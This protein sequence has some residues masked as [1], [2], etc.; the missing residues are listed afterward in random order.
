[1]RNHVRPA[2]PALP[3]RRARSRRPLR[4][5]VAASIATAVVGG[6][7][8]L[9]AHAAPDDPATVHV[10]DPDATAE[11]RSLFAYLDDVRGDGI[12]FGHQHTTS[13]GLTT[14]PSD[15]TTSDVK[16]D[17]GDFPAV[18]GWDTLILQ[19]DEAPGSRSATTAQNVAALADY[20]EKADALGGINTLSAHMENFVTGGSFYDTTGDTLR[21]VLPG[22][23]KNADL[24]AYLDTIA[25][26]AG[27]VHDADGNLI[28][29]IFRPWH[30]N[31]GSWFWWGAAFG[32]PG[33]YQE[34]FRYTVEY[35][36][37]VRG[38]HNLL[39]AFSP[40]GGFGG[41]H[42]QY[43][44]TYPGDAFVDVLGLD[45][46][47]DT[48]SQA[49]L[50]GLVADL[51]M[52]ADEADDRGKVSAFTE[53]G[54]SGGVGT[55]GASPE[56]WFTKVLD[57]I[58]GDPQ[59]SRNSYMLTWANFDAGQ[60]F[61]PVPGDA[62]L[63]D[64]QEFAAD[65]YVVL[66]SEVTGAFDRSTVAAPAS[67]VIHVVSPADGSR[68]AAAPLTVR[69]RVDH[70]DATAVVAHLAK[71]AASVDVP[72]SFDGGLWWTGTWSPAADQLDNSTWSLTATA[73]LAG[74]SS[75]ETSG[76]VVL[77]PR[78]TFPAGVVDD[79]EGYGDDTALRAEYVSYGANTLS[80]STAEHGG[81]AKALRM[82]YDFATQTYTGFGKQV[83]ADWSAFSQ[84]S[85]WI[86]PDGSHNKLVL[87]LVA[88]GV[89]YEAYPS[90]AGTTASVVT[91]PFAD[92]RPAP[93][94][95]AHAD[96][97]ITPDDLANV[98]Q[99][100]VYVN[101]VDGGASSGAVVVDDIA[102][103]V[104]PPVFSDVP[105]GHPYEKEILWA[106]GR[107]LDTGYP[108]GTFR[109]TRLETRGA[110]A[111][112]LYRYS[113][114]SF[115]PTVTKPTFR[116]VPRRSTAFTPVEWMVAQGLAS[117]TLPVFLPDAPLDRSSAAQVLW[118]YAGSPAPSAA[119]AF[120]DV[121][122][123]FPNRDAIAWAT[124]TGVIPPQ[125]ATTFGV[126][127][128]VT[129][130]EAVAFVYRLDHLPKPVQP[131]VLYD[132]ASGAQGWAP[133]AGSATGVDGALSVDSPSPD[134]TWVGVQTGS[135]DLTGRT[136]LAF[137]LVR[138][139]G[140]DTKV[141]LQVGSSWTWCES[142]LTGWISAPRVGD[143]PVVLD[144]TTL[145]PECQAGL[146]DVK[147]I[148]LYLNAGQHVLDDVEVR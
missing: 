73:T 11:T 108:D 32:S 136:A 84:L 16:N 14:G 39:Y 93:W 70:A 129:R 104:G 44:R 95:T 125:S 120:R 31:A 7:G 92:W 148:N 90:L 71:G 57:A 78:P 27:S 75:L 26:L 25:D 47:D 91:V 35:L 87:Q 94:D 106:Y 30:E 124:Q 116:D 81:G 145:S 77:G 82:S 72:L 10:V 51:R 15:G 132:F 55:N 105:H 48:G 68:V 130:Q 63:P 123:W 126:L 99:L 24:D 46:Y 58:T 113:G 135:L 43:L 146:N 147:G 33:E 8:A 61:V 97:R 69:V 4:A 67:P 37:D 56:R 89:S 128:P 49:F 36:R 112:L 74:G 133:F 102:A 117:T 50:D 96:R 122:S 13:F 109:P 18:F 140:V 59:A 131:T 65:P 20:V 9:P 142:A 62:L 88:G 6:I 107:G 29:I 38:V 53:F 86:Q 119:P 83:G 17:T 103:Q 21:A 60:H 45:T 52:I 41:D 85:A 5:A 118:Q 19:G 40:G 79:F 144:L 12:L 111:T 134:G 143:D 110:A 54:V 98:T 64:F 3:A 115:T 76:S 1:M 121:P 42:A 137:D 127:K 66:A 80:L 23:A 139:T 2:R 22:G 114:T 101:S 100:N 28:P 141:A 138:T 34:L